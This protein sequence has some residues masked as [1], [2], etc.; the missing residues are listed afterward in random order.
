ML[1]AHAQLDPAHDLL[2][3]RGARVY[4]HDRERVGSAVAVRIQDHHVGE[5]FRRGLHRLARRGV[6]DRVW[7]QRSHKM[8]LLSDS[9]VTLASHVLRSGNRSVRHLD[10]SPSLDRGSGFGQPLLERLP[11]SGGKR[12]DAKRLPR[13]FQVLRIEV[14]QAADLPNRHSLGIGPDTVDHVAGADLAFFQDA[15]VEAYP[16][17]GKKPLLE[18]AQSHFYAELVARDARLCDFDQRVAHAKN[19]ADVDLVFR[20][21]LDGEVFPKLSEGEIGSTKLTLPVV[22]VLDRVRVGGFVYSAV[23]YK[24]RLPVTVEVQR[25]EHDPSV[26]RL[27]ENS[28]RYRLTPMHNSPRRRN[29]YGEQLHPM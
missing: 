16:A 11:P 13:S 22:V 19:V 27:F 5:L 24:I 14:E 4:V 15:Q 17:T 10:R 29:V 28:R 3:G 2:V 20:H 23:A 7:S 25:P 9:F 6:E 21:A 18:A 12:T 1:V 26:D 8:S